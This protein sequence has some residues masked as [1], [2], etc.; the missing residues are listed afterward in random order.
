MKDRTVIC[1]ACKGPALYGDSN[2]WRPF[3]CGRCRNADL[4]AW[5]NDDYRVAAPPSA[6]ELDEAEPPAQPLAP[7]H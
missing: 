7:R 4:G 6:D 3:C 1:P 5:A 2:P